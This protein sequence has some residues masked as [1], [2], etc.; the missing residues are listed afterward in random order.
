M[1]PAVLALTGG[2]ALVAAVAG[3]ELRSQWLASTLK[4]LPTSDQSQITEDE[5][6]ALRIP[7]TCGGYRRASSTEGGRQQ[8]YVK[9]K[10]TVSLF[11][12]GST[13]ADIAAAPGWSTQAGSDG[14]QFYTLI[15]QNDHCAVAFTYGNQPIV[16]ASRIKTGRLIEFAVQLK[17]A[18]R[19]RK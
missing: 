6:L 5:S 7:E 16:L 12:P 11:I 8:I 15:G 4:I 18:M 2:T 19:D 1:K 9:G 14:S 3:W 10:N 17:A 13:A